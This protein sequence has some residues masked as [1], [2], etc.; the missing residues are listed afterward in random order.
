M[1]FA[2]GK[3]LPSALYIAGRFVTPEGRGSEPIIN[4]ANEA[5]VGEAPIGGVD[6]AHA[7]ISAARVAFDRGP[8]PT[9]STRQRTAYLE[10]MY[11]ALAARASDT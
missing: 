11:E 7:A 9:L 8:W 5:L 1:Q 6:D 4:P 3:P 10:R 2:S